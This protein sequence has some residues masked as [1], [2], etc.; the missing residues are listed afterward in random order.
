MLISGESISRPPRGRT[1]RRTDGQTDRQADRQAG[2]R[3]PSPRGNYGARQ[4]VSLFNSLS[5]WRRD[6][7]RPVRSLRP[8]HTMTSEAVPFSSSRPT[9]GRAQRRGLT[10]CLQGRM[11]VCMRDRAAVCDMLAMLAAGGALRGAAG[12]Q[13]ENNAT[14]TR[15]CSAQRANLA[16]GRP[17]SPTPAGP[18]AGPHSCPVASV[19]SERGRPAKRAGW[20]VG[21][22]ASTPRHSASFAR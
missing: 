10:A 20:L 9:R 19:A 11:C 14:Q 1:D 22:A 3:N 4:R 12:G 5:S 18:L 2:S 21:P 6:A 17:A 8:A 7:W 13:N 16:R 15:F